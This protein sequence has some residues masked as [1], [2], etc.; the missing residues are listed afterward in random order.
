M[1]PSRLDVLRVLIVDDEPMAREL[2]SSMLTAVGTIEVIGE[3]RTAD[4]AIAAIRNEDP[5]LVFLD[6]E[7]P[8]GDGFSVIEAIG[9]QQMPTTVFTTAYDCYAIRAFEVLATDYLLK[10]F[11]ERRLETTLTRVAGRRHDPKVMASHILRALDG[12][13]ETRRYVDRLAVEVADHVRFV[14]TADIDWIEAKGKHSLVHTNEATYVMREG[15][16]HVAVR[17]DPM[18]FLRIH[19]SS[20]V[21]VDRIQQVHRWFRGDYHLVLT[22]GTRLTSGSTYRKGIQQLLLGE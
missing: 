16:A 1:M 18:E 13:R 10:P 3:C 19:R 12:L 5:D 14:P 15:L 22:D 17:L 20:V 8:G 9:V 21:R 2:L 11:D 7:M 4:E 6:V